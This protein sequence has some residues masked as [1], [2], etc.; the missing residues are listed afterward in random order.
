MPFVERIPKYC[1]VLVRSNSLK[2]KRLDWVLRKGGRIR[3]F[4]Q[5]LG[6]GS[7]W[8]KFR[9]PPLTFGRA[10]PVAVGQTKAEGGN[11]R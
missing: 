9:R 10:L 5:D 1:P 6:I 2:R 4:F 3:Q 7:S 8:L 11:E